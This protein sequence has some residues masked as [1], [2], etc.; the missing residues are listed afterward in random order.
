[1]LCRKKLSPVRRR[2]RRMIS[3]LLMVAVVSV[4]Y[5]EWAVRAQLGDVIAAELKSVAESAVDA[6]V[7]GYLSAYPGVG[8]TLCA[9][10]RSESG[11]VTSVTTD[12]S[13]VNLAKTAISED[14]RRRIGSAVSGQGLSVPAGSFTGLVCLSSVG[15]P[16]SLPVDC[17]ENL[18]CHFKS[19]FTSAGLNQTLHHITMTAEVSLTVYNPYRIRREIRVSSDYEIAQTVIVGAVPAYG[20][21]LT[22]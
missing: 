6:A 21:V 8:E 7:A 11:A 20:G 15:P 12:P 10:Q 18:V 17:K 14:A 9:V 4:A 19:E 3:W 22:Y 5:F 2:L 1:M 16:V 13:A